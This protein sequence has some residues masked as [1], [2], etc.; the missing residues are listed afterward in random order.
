MRACMPTDSTH[1][2]PWVIQHR[3]RTMDDH[4]VN[5]EKANFHRIKTHPAN[6]KV[7]LLVLVGWLLAGWPAE[8]WLAG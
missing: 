3:H 5:K 7:V 1:T 4:L 2:Q 6:G 8:C